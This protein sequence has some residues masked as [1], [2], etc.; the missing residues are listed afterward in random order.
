MRY[1]VSKAQNLYNSH[2]TQSYCRANQ[3]RFHQATFSSRG[4]GELHFKRNQRQILNF[5]QNHSTIYEYD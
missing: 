2:I 5:S 3:S 1:D 4:N